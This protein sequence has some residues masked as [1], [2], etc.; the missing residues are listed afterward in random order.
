MH[1]VAARAIAKG[2]GP[3]DQLALAGMGGEAA[4]GMNLR[5]YREIL[6]QYTH[7]LGAVNNLS[8]QGAG[9]LKP[10]YHQ[11]GRGLF[12]IVTE[13]VNDSA[14]GTH[15][16]PS[17]ND[18]TATNAVDRHRLLYRAGH[19]QNG[20]VLVGVAASGDIEHFEVFR[21]QRLARSVIELGYFDGHGAVKKDQLLA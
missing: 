16:C 15:A 17:N 19:A 11:P 12:Q 7:S 2:T 21:I 10:H 3:V 5:F 6:A 14:T 13:V 4:N 9:R 20:Q 8:A 1:Q 18:G